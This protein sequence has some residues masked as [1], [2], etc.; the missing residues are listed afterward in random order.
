MPS[1]SPS[2]LPGLD[3]AVVLVT[4]GARGVGAGITCS[5]LRA[6]VNVVTCGRTV[7][8]APVTDRDLRSA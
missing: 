6:G 2:S 5:F 7:P 8:D 1:V 4:G 3:G